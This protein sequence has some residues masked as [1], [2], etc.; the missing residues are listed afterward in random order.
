VASGDLHGQA[1][2]S[3]RLADTAIEHN[4]RLCG[5]H[6]RRGKLDCAQN[7]LASRLSPESTNHG[8]F[9]LIKAAKE[10][11]IGSSVLRH[12]S[13]AGLAMALLATFHS[14]LLLVAR[15]SVSVDQY[16]HILLVIPV[17]ATLLY[18]DRR[19]IFSDVR[20]SILAGTVL[21][22]A[23]G[24]Y[25]Y[26]SWKSGALYSSGYISLS[27]FLF[28]VTFDSA[29]SLCYGSRAFRKAAFPLLFLLLA[30]PLPDSALSHVIASLQNGSAVAA[31][32]LFRLAHVPYV[33]HGVVLALPRIDIYIAEE[34]SG[35]RSSMVLLL[36]TLVLGHLYL[37]S[38]W[39]QIAL[40]ILVLPLM[41]A[42]N[43]LRIFVL[44]MLG[45]YVDP[46][47]LTG[48]LHHDGGFIFFG[49]A[50]A[51]IFGVIWLFRKIGL[52]SG[53]GAP[54]HPP[55]ILQPGD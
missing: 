32:L 29:F 7:G 5:G 42:K 55:G 9:R 46:S 47:F 34:C 25:G 36:S 37:K 10:E 54:S 6:R 51:G 12:A 21:L 20:S 1:R 13:F 18:L 15:L 53:T 17:S 26:A 49:I 40:A 50:F 38:V 35:I 39:G 31:C 19:R 4:S 44:S 48:R 3:D 41:V 22:G 2:V 8:F 30:V 23:L 45:M 16:S 24:T 43:G 33:R 28:A 27:V 14:P 11:K 52:D